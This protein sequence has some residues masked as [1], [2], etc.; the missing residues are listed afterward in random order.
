MLTM[1]TVI[2]AT[3]LTLTAWAAHAAADGAFLPP[4]N[5]LGF[6]GCLITDSG[7]VVVGLDFPDVRGRMSVVI[8]K[9]GEPRTQALDVGGKW[10]RLLP[11]DRIWIYGYKLV[12]GVDPYE[13]SYEHGDAYFVHQIYRIGGSNLHLEREFEISADEIETGHTKVTSDFQTW[14]RMANLY[15][16][17]RKTGRI[18]G[19]RGRHF[20]LGKT[21]SRK[22]RRTEDLELYPDVYREHDE[23]A[24]EIVDPEGLVLLASYA[25]D[26]FLIRFR[27]YGVDSL[28][29]D[30]LRHVVDPRGGD[31][32]V[33]WQPEDR[34]LWARKGSEWLAYDL[35]D[36]RYQLAVPEA[37]FLRRSA[38]HGSP[39]PMRGFV[40]V[41]TDGDR[42][43]VRHSWRSPRFESREKT[44]V[45]E[46]RNGPLPA[47]VSP[48][49]RHA[50]VLESR[51]TEEGEVVTHAGRFGLDLAP[52]IPPVPAL[53]DDEDRREDV[54]PSPSRP[55]RILERRVGLVFATEVDSLGQA[56]SF[57][58]ATPQTVSVSLT[59]MNR[60]FDCSVNGS[61]CSNRDGARDDTG[62]GN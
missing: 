11:G 47:A 15:T 40:E 14:V 5:L 34:V 48:N 23:S 25:T 4:G 46:W 38:A 62:R 2:F 53:A 3:L 36:V 24:F 13:D 28:P 41:E 51:H 21:S 31:L 43:R 50:L 60:N 55:F 49:G 45:S 29:V 58:L 61:F 54:Q 12:D 16:K 6:G 59:G 37:P 42:H 1:R 56:Y 20:S 10:L 35:R 8:W 52:V 17:D 9:G 33:V 32:D 26:L 18:Y 7:H 22:A 27:D 57:A 30:H 39:H 44:H 19:V